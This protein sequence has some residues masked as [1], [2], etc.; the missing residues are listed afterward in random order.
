[1]NRVRSFLLGASMAALVSSAFA[2][3]GAWNPR[4]G[5][6]NATVDRSRPSCPSAPLQRR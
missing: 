6:R 5:E 2:A 3:D 1:M 4:T